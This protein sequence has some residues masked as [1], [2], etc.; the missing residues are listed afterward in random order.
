MHY[1]PNVTR[2]ILKNYEEIRK[3]ISS[4]CYQYKIDSISDMENDFY[5]RLIE[6]KI[7]QKYDQRRRPNGKRPFNPGDGRNRTEISTYLYTVINNMAK[8]K[9]SSNEAKIAQKKLS[10]DV[11]QSLNKGTKNKLKWDERKIP[12]DVKYESILHKNEMSNSIDGLPLDLNLFEAYLEKQLKAN[13]KKACVGT[14]ANI[15][16]LDVFRLLRAGCAPCDLAQLYGVTDMWMSM[17]KKELKK[18]MLKFG[19]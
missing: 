5:L 17:L 12:V 2:F 9:I 11:L 19:L 10:L 16:L 6:N 18:Y 7:L 8:A 1:T 3:I 15:N 13:P 14:G 4:V